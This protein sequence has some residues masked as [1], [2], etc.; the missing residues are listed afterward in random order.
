LLSKLY[1]EKQHASSSS[2]RSYFYQIP[3]NGFSRANLPYITLE[4]EEGKNTKVILDLGCCV[5]PLKLSREFLNTLD[6]KFVIRSESFG[7]RGKRY[8]ND[9]YEISKINMGDVTLTSFYAAEVNEEFNKDSD[10]VHGKKSDD[11]ENDTFA[12]L[13]GWKI[14][15]KYNLFLDC[16]NS[17]IAMCDSLDT[18]KKE[19]YPVESYVE[20][21]LLL[22]RDF[23]EFIAMTEKG[24]LRCVLD[25]GATL[26]F[27]NKDLDGGS[28]EHMIFNPDNMHLHNEL[29]P[30]NE[31]KLV[32][33]PDDFYTMSMFQIGTKDFGPMRFHRIKM[34]IEA[35]AFIG[36]DFLKYVQMFIDFP[37]SKIYFYEPPS[38]TASDQQEQVQE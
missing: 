3:I 35:D 7:M 9:V 20:T 12:S 13:L 31:D 26:S 15:R 16:K 19:G 5:F 22:D 6:K 4:T 23:L 14:F 21:P 36:M 24:P 29:N 34:P 33:I 25:S 2:Q 1:R 11:A 37:N 28:N 8:E 38:E 30:N 10:L 27:L 32:F 17:L 18:L